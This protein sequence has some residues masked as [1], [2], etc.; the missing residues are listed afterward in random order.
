MQAHMIVCVYVCIY[1]YIYIY[2][3]REFS[4]SFDIDGLYKG[5]FTLCVLKPP[6]PAEWIRAFQSTDI[7]YEAFH[8]K[9]VRIFTAAVPLRWWRQLAI[10]FNMCLHTT[11]LPLCVA[12][13]GVDYCC[14]RTYLM[15]HNTDI[16]L[17]ISLVEMKSVLRIRR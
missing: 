4:T 2:I 13:S 12:S 8:T 3:Y 5:P 16:E 11:Q 9:A 14:S 7:P 15:D 17:L 6:P 1:I 10:M